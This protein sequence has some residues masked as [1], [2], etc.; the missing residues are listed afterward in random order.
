MSEMFIINLLFSS[1]RKTRETT[2]ETPTL[3]R[4]HIKEELIAIYSSW[5]SQTGRVGSFLCCKRDGCG[6]WGENFEYS[7]SD[8][9]LRSG[10][11]KWKDLILDAKDKQATCYG[12]KKYQQKRKMNCIRYLSWESILHVTVGKKEEENCLNIASNFIFNSTLH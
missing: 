12:K 11:K 8:F 9:L 6:R 2:D 1:F 5:T 7:Y 4:I 3:E 10:W